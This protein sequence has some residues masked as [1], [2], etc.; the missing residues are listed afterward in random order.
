MDSKGK[1]VKGHNVT[2]GKFGVCSDKPGY[3]MPTVGTTVGKI[4]GSGT[5][6]SVFNVCTSL[7]KASDL[8]GTGD[9]DD[10]VWGT[11]RVADNGVDATNTLPGLDLV[12]WAEV[13]VTDHVCGVGAISAVVGGNEGVCSATHLV[14]HF[15]ATGAG[16]IDANNNWVL[17]L[18][19]GLY[20]DAAVF[21]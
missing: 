1:A 12:N 9:L 20:T 11:T 3:G 16:L 8:E 19:C 7:A 6:G 14:G 10:T 4:N 2:I 18:N 21:G 15:G 5:V 13:E 17:P